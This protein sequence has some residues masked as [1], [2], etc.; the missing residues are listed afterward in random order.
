MKIAN[1]KFSATTNFFTLY[2]FQFSMFLI[3]A[4]DFTS[5]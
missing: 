1:R 3:E 2:S 5:S 4:D